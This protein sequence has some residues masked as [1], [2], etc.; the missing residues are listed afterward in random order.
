MTR[1]KGRKR[2]RRRDFDDEGLDRLF[3]ETPPGV[4]RTLQEIADSAHC[5]RQKIYYIEQQALKKIR[6]GY[7]RYGICIDQFL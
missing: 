7:A 4:E 5:L 6:A 2:S 1:T 3:R